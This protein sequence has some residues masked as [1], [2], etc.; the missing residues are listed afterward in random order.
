MVYILLAE[1]FEEIEVI[2]PLDIMRRGGIDVKTVSIGGKSVKGAHGIK[3]EADITIDEIEDTDLEMIVLPG[4][5]GHELL[6]ASNKVH[7]LINYA[8]KED[9]YIAAICA[10][11]SIL[12]KK[13]MLDGKKAVAYPGFEKWLYGAEVQDTKTAL[14]GKILTGKGPGAAAEFGFSIVKLLKGKKT[15]EDLRCAMQY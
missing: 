6:D 2:E 3:V 5:A 8:V 14:D 7:G 10:A 4:G 9:L 15:A 12:G 13:G 11:P 1:D